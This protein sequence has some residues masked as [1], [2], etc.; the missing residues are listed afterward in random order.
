MNFEKFIVDSITKISGKHT[1]YQVFTD[2]V[3]MTA[4]SI[5]NACRIIHDKIYK[6]REDIYLSISKRYSAD[7]L[8]TFSHM[9]GALTILLEERFYDVLGDIYMKTGCGNKNTGQFF[10]PYH[11]SYLAAE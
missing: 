1:P 7:E 9:T 8:K 4:V 11:L 10:T 6:D 2:W 5:Q 3:C